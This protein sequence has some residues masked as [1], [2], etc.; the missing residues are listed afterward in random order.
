[1]FG[2]SWVYRLERW[3]E[4]LSTGVTKEDVARAREVYHL[5]KIGPGNC[6][7]KKLAILELMVWVGRVTW[8]MNFKISRKESGDGESEGYGRRFVLRDA[9][10]GLTDGLIV[11]FERRRA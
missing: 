7:G 6:A 3:I 9:Y 1:M 10:I 8:R 2:D 11:Q 5:F 4:D